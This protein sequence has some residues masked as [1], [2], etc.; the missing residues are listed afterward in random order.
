M[1]LPMMM[2]TEKLGVLTLFKEFDRDYYKPIRIDGGFAGR[3]NYIEYK[4]IE[5]RYEKLITLGIS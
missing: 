5:D 2:N 3:N 1:I 4:S